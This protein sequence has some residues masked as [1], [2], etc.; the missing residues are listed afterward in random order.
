M[1]ELY[2]ALAAI[3]HAILVAGLSVAYISAFAGLLGYLE[4]RTFFLIALFST[5]AAFVAAVVTFAVRDWR[6][7]GGGLHK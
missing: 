4:P 3:T 1:D 2:R 5:I 6:L 7:S